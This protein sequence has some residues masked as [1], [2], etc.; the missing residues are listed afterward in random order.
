MLE[1]KIVFVSG[2]TGYIGSA[3]CKVCSDYGAKVIFSYYKNKD[4]ATELKSELKSAIDIQLDINDVKEIKDKIYN[5]NQEI[6]K[7]D[8]LINNAGVSQVMPFSLL[9]ESDLDFILDTNVKGTFFLTKEIVRKMIKYK[10]GSIVNIGSI[11][12]HRIL[13]VP[14]HYAL[15]KSAISGFTF[16]LAAE[17]KRFNIRVNSVVPGMLEDGVAKGIPDELR[18]DYLKHCLIG[19][20]GK[21]KEVAEVVCFLASDKASYINGQNLFVDGGI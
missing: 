19:R 16:S 10:T 5:L 12:G 7:I 15:S 17:L 2:G 1:N 8:I 11:A 3:I 13:D 20:P 4:Q 6:D 9:E 18:E 21:G 14:V